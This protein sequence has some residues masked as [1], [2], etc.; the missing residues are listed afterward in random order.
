MIVRSRSPVRLSFGGGG[1]DVPPYCD[2]RGGC[3]VSATI[4][5][6]SYGTLETRD[7]KKINID[8]VDFLNLKKIDNLSLIESVIRSM[9]LTGRGLNVFLRSDVPPRSGLGSS[10]AT[11]AAMIGLFNHLKTK[12]RMTRHKIAETAYELERKELGIGG[13]YQDQYATVFGGINFIEFFGNGKVQVNPI[14]MKKDHMLELEKHLLLVYTMDRQISGGD[15]IKDQTKRFKERKSKALDVT[16]EI[17]QD[18][19]YALRSGN[20]ME[21]GNL[22]HKAW[23]SKKK[24]S[25]LISNKKI[26]NLYNLARKN[27]ALGGKLTGAGGGGFMLF[28]CEPNKEHRVIEALKMHNFTPLTITFDFEG[29]QTW[30]VNNV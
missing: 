10:A 27:G 5:K 11:F 3:V 8:S 25:P 9:N 2:E 7:D 26:D 13:G 28:F 30:N 17:A 20:L 6:Y 24:H 14:N 1:T 18:M 12:D 19:H 16:K 15:I 29:L 23:M 4:N 21:F 22:L